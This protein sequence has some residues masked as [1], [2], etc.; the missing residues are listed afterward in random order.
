MVRLL[1]LAAVLA[2]AAAAD[3]RVQCDSVGEGTKLA[4]LPGSYR[5]VTAASARDARYAPA[6]VTF[7]DT[8]QTT[9]WAHLQVKTDPSFKDAD[10]MFGAG[11]A[12]GYATHLRMLQ[13]MINVH[14]MA[15]GAGQGLQKGPP[16]DAWEKTLN[17]LEAHLDWVKA[18]IASKPSEPL[19][20]MVNLLLRQAEGMV[21]GY[22]AGWAQ[23]PLPEPTIPDDSRRPKHL[24]PGVELTLLQLFAYNSMGDIPDILGALYPEHQKSCWDMPDGEAR[25]RIERR[26]H[27]TVMIKPV[28]VDGVPDLGISHV[29]WYD[30]RT[31]LRI[32]KDYRFR[33]DARPNYQVMMS[34]Y[35]GVVTSFDDFYILPDRRM[36]VTETTNDICNATLYKLIKP[37]SLLSWQ[38]TMAANIYAYNGPSWIETFV[39]HNS[40]TYNNQFMILDTRQ[41]E[42]SPFHGLTVHSNALWIVEQIPGKTRSL[43]V[44]AFLKNGTGQRGH[45]GSWNRN[46]FPEF[47]AEMGYAKAAAKYGDFYSY[48]SCPRAK[49]FKRDVDKVSDI[50]SFQNF[51]EYNDW[52][53][54]PIS[55]GNPYNAISARGDLVPKDGKW[56]SPWMERS[57]SGG[58]DCKLTTAGWLRAS[59]TSTRARATALSGPTR[60]QQPAWDWTAQEWKGLSHLGHPDSQI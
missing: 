17:W 49:I 41:V 59:A 58:T 9:G 18:E 46:F 21:E 40:G 12:E 56:P 48:A 2:V 23:H 53:N 34:S 16:V 32:W 43:D 7:N 11:Y 28:M 54:D 25:D 10:Q 60:V 15:Y 26:N 47:H 6:T 37:Q 30:Y 52:E 4:C 45:W 39:K 8:V 55:E 1:A 57:A 22:N 24:Q 33:L 44:S 27:C 31:M 51:M 38:R 29:T 13:H 36:V 50:P 42:S 19:W 3:F 14:E 35:P 20:Y 5:L